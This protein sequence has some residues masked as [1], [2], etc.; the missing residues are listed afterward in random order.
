MF[1]SLDRDTIRIR[2]DNPS[3]H[4]PCGFHTFFFSIKRFLILMNLA[5]FTIFGWEE[6]SI[7]KSLNMDLKAVTFH[8][9]THWCERSHILFT[10]CITNWRNSVEIPFLAKTTSSVWTIEPKQFVGMII[11]TSGC[12]C[13]VNGPCDEEI[14]I[15]FLWPI[16]WSCHQLLNPL[17]F[18]Y[19]VQHLFFLIPIIFGSWIVIVHYCH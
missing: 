11:G 15:P 9:Y 19:R 14:T 12:S 8:V 17:L 3:K 1:E 2:N 16:S 5:M 4:K 18:L 13:S 7:N 10:Y 6:C